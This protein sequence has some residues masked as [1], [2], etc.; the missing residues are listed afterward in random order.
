MNEWVTVRALK[1]LPIAHTRTASATGCRLAVADG[2]AQHLRAMPRH[3]RGTG[4]SRS[5]RLAGDWSA[6][7]SLQLFTRMPGFTRTALDWE[8]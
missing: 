6:Q 7:S 1:V 5:C 4:R 8:L 2:L 3:R